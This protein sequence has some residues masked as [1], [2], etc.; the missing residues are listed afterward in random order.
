MEH[1]KLVTEVFEKLNQE[2]LSLKL[3]KCDFGKNEVNWL[4]S[5]LSENGVTPKIT[6][7]KAKLKLEFPKL[8]KQLRSFL[9][10]INHLSKF[11]PIA[12][13]LTDELRPLLPQENEKKK[14]KSI[15]VPVKKFE[16]GDEHSLVFE[17]MQRRGS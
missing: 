1:K 6:I 4:R 12:A 14:L 10:K 3:S 7:T 11:I 9:R 17:E 15:K 13:K 2:N 8:M 5:N 16:W